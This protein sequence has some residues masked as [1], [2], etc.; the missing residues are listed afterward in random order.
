MGITN[1]RLTR[2]LMV[3]G[4]AT[5]IDQGSKLIYA[6]S[7]RTSLN[8]GISFGWL[9]Q[10]PQVVLV[11]LLI[12]VFSCLV[13]FLAK[14][15]ELSAVAAGLITGGGLSNVIDRLAF[16]GVRDW[17]PI[18]LTSLQNN[19]ADYAIAMGVAWILWQLYRRGTIAAIDH[20]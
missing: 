7:S 9:D 13:F 10:L 4:G 6:V 1:S 5:L 19:L 16:G 11:V 17:L 8:S 12:G 15:Q 18:P 2:I 3:A 20:D 14:N